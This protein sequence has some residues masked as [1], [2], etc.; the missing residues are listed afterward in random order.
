M[1]EWN[2]KLHVSMQWKLTK[3]KS[4]WITKVFRLSATRDSK[5]YMQY[6]SIFIILEKAKL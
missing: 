3:K 5:G 1:G 4:E 2:N 6:D